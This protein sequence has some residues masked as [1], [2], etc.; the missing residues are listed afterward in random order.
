M[1]P[2]LHG[3][4]RAHVR[5]HNTAARGLMAGAEMVKP[6]RL[7]AK[8]LELRGNSPSKTSQWSSAPAP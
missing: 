1:L 2:L 6:T 4:Q 3:A 7:K 5:K 8:V